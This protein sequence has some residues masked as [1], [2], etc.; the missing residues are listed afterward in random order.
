[1]G[2]IRP[3]FTTLQTHEKAELKNKPN[4]VTKRRHWN[5]FSQA[6]HVPL[7]KRWK[8]NLHKSIQVLML[9]FQSKDVQQNAE[10]NEGAAESVNNILLKKKKNGGWTLKLQILGDLYYLLFAVALFRASN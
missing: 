8:R 5:D 3:I 7:L 1:M 10:W 9:K 2:A 4:S 6:F